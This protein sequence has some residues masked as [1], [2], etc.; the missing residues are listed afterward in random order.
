MVKMKNLLNGN[1]WLW[2]HGKFVDR[3]YMIQDMYQRYLDG[4]DV[5]SIPREEDPFWEPTEDILI[6]TA[7]IFLQ[8]LVNAMDFSDQLS[9]TDYK[10]QEEGKLRVNIIPCTQ[11]GLALDEDN[12]VEDSK[13]LLNKP[14]HF[15]VRGGGQI[16]SMLRELR[17]LAE[18]AGIEMWG[19]KE[20][21]RGGERERE[22]GGDMGKD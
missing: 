19:G 16:I 11:A 6:G 20:G 3:K 2:P 5:N 12:Y 4:E 8:S 10:G 17:D 7:D 22:R 18:K 1:T 9:I 13:E 15:K 21:E 14:F